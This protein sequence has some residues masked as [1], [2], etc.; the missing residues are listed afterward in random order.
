MSMLQQDDRG[1]VMALFQ[2]LAAL[3]YR[4]GRDSLPLP[5]QGE[6]AATCSVVCFRVMGA[7]VAILLDEVRELLNVPFCTRLPRVKPWVRGVAN[8]RGNLMPIIDFAAYLGGRLQSHPK[9]HRVLVVESRGLVAGLV[10]D[11][12]I[13]MKHLRI[14][15]F[16]E[17]RREL[18]RALGPYVSG[19]FTGEDGSWALLR[20]EA[21]LSHDAFLDV[22]AIQPDVVSSPMTHSGTQEPGE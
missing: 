3:S 11:E 2:Q 16:S 7:S 12:V 1:D 13:G 6:V 15:S 20:P 21:L 22:A 14:A 19:S 10:V 17:Q 9:S 8:V 4:Y 18:P 5:A